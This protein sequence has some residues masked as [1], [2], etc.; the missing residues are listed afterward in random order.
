MNTT[1]QK[2]S[3][4]ISLENSLKKKVGSGGIPARL[5]QEAQL[6][7]DENPAEFKEDGLEILKGIQKTLAQFETAP[8]DKHPALL[9]ELISDVMVLKAHGA[10]FH[11]ELVSMIAD[12]LLDFLETVQTINPDVLEIIKAHNEI[13]QMALSR[14]M[15]GNGGK[16]GIALS[17]ELFKACARYYEKH[18][19]N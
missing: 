16:E 3:R 11:Y 13:I 4:L 15:K 1:S 10:M 7:I 18:E 12:V 8:Q 5:L 9:E 2:Q 14:Q 19:T 17:R 6:Y